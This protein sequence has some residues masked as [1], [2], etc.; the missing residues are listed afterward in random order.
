MTSTPDD[1]RLRLVTA[2][3]EALNLADRSGEFVAAAHLSAARDALRVSPDISA[4]EIDA[5]FD[6]AD[7]SEG[8]QRPDQQKQ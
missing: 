4:A 8:E 7:E 6:A 3:E 2:I 1:Q 5:I